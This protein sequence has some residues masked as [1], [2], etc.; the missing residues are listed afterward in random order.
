M[1]L[2]QPAFCLKCAMRSIVNYDE[3]ES[4][5]SLSNMAIIDTWKSFKRRSANKKLPYIDTEGMRL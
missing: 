4:Q 5:T 3:A 1:K 2:G